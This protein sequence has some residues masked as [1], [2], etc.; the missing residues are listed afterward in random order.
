ML[1]EFEKKCC[2]FLENVLGKFEKK[3]LQKNATWFKICLS[4]FKPT[5]QKLQRQGKKINRSFFEK[6]LDKF[7]LI[8]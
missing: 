4:N 2:I 3:V 1:K 6:T 8:E 7:M 5:P